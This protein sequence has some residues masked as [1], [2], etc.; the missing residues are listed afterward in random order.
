MRRYYW[1]ALALVI[2][3]LAAGTANT[4]VSK[5]YIT[6]R[7]ISEDLR[8]LDME[9]ISYHSQNHKLPDT[10]NQLDIKDVLKTRI[11][12]YEYAPGSAVAA[13]VTKAPQAGLYYRPEPLTQ[14][15][16]TLCATFKTATNDNR[17]KM[18]TSDSFNPETH[19]KGRQCFTD[20][21]T[22]NETAPAL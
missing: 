20:Y 22:V 1:S 8:T 16:F 12:D 10:L 3:A 9:I 6:D 17:V 15:S 19:T 5:P 11:K 13:A 4:L 18:Q 7:I 2:I 14:E 21:V